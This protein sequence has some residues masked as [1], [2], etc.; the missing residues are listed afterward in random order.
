[1][2]IKFG[3]NYYQSGVVRALASDISR[4]KELA[5]R[6]IRDTKFIVKK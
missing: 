6:V 4:Q 5:Q 2:G 3:S 1:M